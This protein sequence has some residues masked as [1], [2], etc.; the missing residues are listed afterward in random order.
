MHEGFPSSCRSSRP[1]SGGGCGSR[2]GLDLGQL[3]PT[4]L[5]SAAHTGAYSY[6]RRLDFDWE[7][8]N[9]RLAILPDES[10]RRGWRESS[11]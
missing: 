6:A 2:I 11:Q 3:L 1:L 4:K 9:C 8:P 5:A 10:T 7:T